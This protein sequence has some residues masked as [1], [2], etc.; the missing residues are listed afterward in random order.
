MS[1]LYIPQ[2]AMSLGMRL[3]QEVYMHQTVNIIITNFRKERAIKL[4]HISTSISTLTWLLATEKVELRPMGFLLRNLS[5]YENGHLSGMSSGGKLYIDLHILGLLEQWLVEGN[6]T[7]EEA[8]MQSCDMMAVGI[9]TVRK[10]L[11]CL[12]SYSAY[13]KVRV[14]RKGE[15]RPT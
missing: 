13:K 14:R 6:Y 4:D 5:Y 3:P 7:E 9:D 10:C 11:A 15:T 2:I 1:R 8:L 12:S